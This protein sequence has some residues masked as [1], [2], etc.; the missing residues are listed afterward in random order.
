MSVK[1]PELTPDKIPETPEEIYSEAKKSFVRDGILLDDP[2]VIGAMDES[3]SGHF[4]PVKYRRDG[5]LSAKG[6]LYSSDELKSLCE[7][8][9]EKAASVACKIKHG[10]S[11]AIP[12]EHT[13]YT[14]SVCEYCPIK[15]ICKKPEFS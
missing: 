13:P 15:E 4:I 8:A 7:A 3:Q 2:D 12:T 9:S 14:S 10:I 6:V 1:T 5:S 11:D